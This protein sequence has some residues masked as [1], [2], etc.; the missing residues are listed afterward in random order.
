MPA[1]SKVY[2]IMLPI[3]RTT[4]IQTVAPNGTLGELGTSATGGT[5]EIKFDL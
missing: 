5:F 4:H 1:T 2:A 3:G